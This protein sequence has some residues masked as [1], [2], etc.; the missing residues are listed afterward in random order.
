METLNNGSIHAFLCVS[1]PCR[2]TT[3]VALRVR[4]QPGNGVTVP[5]E[6]D[7]NNF[8]LSST[9]L[10]VSF[11]ISLFSQRVG[12]LRSTLFQPVPHQLQVLLA[13]HVLSSTHTGRNKP[14]SRCTKRHSHSRY[15]LQISCAQTSCQWMSQLMSFKWYHRILSCMPQVLDSDNVIDDVPKQL[16]F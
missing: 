10:F 7:S 5:A 14:F 13:C 8:R 4:H 15:F 2:K 6:K 16:E 9:I 12:S 1:L 11:A 3:K